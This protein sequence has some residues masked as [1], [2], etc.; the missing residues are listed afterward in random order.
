[1]KELGVYPNVWDHEDAADY[2]IEYFETLQEVYALA[3]ENK[4]AIITFIS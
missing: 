3:V 2:L 1:M 4:E